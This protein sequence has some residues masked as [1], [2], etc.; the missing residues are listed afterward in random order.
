MA[1]PKQ[2]IVKWLDAG[3]MRISNHLTDQECDQ[4]IS[5]TES[6]NHWQETWTPRDRENP[7]GEKYRKCS[8]TKIT[9][10]SELKHLD[11]LIFDRIGQA[12]SKYHDK[13]GIIVS[14]DEGYKVLKYTESDYYNMHYDSA[15]FFS[16]RQISAII[17]LNDNFNGGE[18]EFPNQGIK[19]RPVKG[20]VLIFPSNYLY[21]H[22]VNKIT[23]GIRYAIVTW[24]NSDPR[25]GQPNPPSME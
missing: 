4:I 24:L 22:V 13:H 15:S 21:K 16:H 9:T 12:I 20:T 6:F 7:H 18:L 25:W 17:F 10:Y 3:I 23:D 11:N 14:Y 8:M 5:E 1:K 19:I 2:P